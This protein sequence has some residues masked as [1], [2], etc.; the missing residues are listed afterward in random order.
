M[1]VSGTRSA[2]SPWR[3]FIAWLQGAPIGDPVDRRNAP[4][5]QLVLCFLG[6][7]PLLLWLYRIFLS[8]LPWRS[9]ETASLVSSLVLSAVALAGLVLVRR[10][11]FR[12]AAGALLATALLSMI[13]DYARTGFTA[14]AYEQPAQV[15]WIVLAGLVLGRRA[16]WITYAC[17]LIA[18]AAG[19]ARDLALHAGTGFDAWYNQLVSA[20]VTATIFLL[21]AIVVDRSVAA[22]RESLAEATRRGDELERANRRLENEIEERERLRDQ[23]VHAQKVEAVGRLASGVAH[24]F[25]HLIGLILGYAQANEDS[26]DAGELRA[27]LAGSKAAAQRADALTGTLLGFVRRETTRL[28]IFDAGEVLRGMRPMLLQLF[29]ASVRVVIDTPSN[30]IPIRFD[31]AQLA[32]AVLNIAANA[33]HA[34]PHGGTFHVVLGEPTGGGAAIELAD[35]GAGM[36]DDV[37]RRVFEP[38][39]TTRPVGQGTGLGLAVVADLVAGSGASIEVESEIGRGTAFHLRFPPADAAEPARDGANGRR[40]ERAMPVE[41]T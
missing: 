37:R 22:L 13:V 15:I 26:D 40:R 29:G 23:L 8:G 39:F 3:R 17:H 33:N 19:L 7:V 30:P 5:L 35:T 28:E 6:F 21:I 20:V 38:F 41:E 34:M 12:L 14:Q 32:L 36:P 1:R 16:L 4:M 11:R 31:R 27:A 9:S 10:G 2:V 25:R 24:D 18:F